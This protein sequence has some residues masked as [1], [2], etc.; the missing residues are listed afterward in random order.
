MLRMLKVKQKVSGSFRTKVGAEIFT[1]IMSYLDITNKHGI[2]PF[3]A[4]KAG[5]K[6]ISK[7]LLF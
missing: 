6:G 1:T 3:A 2:N 4:I 5:I 7:E